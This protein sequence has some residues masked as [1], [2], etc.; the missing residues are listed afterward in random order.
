MVTLLF[1]EFFYNPMVRKQNVQALLARGNKTKHLTAGSTLWKGV[2]MGTPQRL[3]TTVSTQGNCDSPSSD[4]GVDAKC[5][6]GVK[7]I[8][9]QSQ[10][11]SILAGVNTT[12]AS[13]H[14]K[15]A[16]LT[17]DNRTSNK[18]GMPIKG[19]WDIVFIT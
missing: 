5:G 10:N 14:Q 13:G 7:K 2:N 18:V 8:A 15:V 3:V 9:Q 4:T 6:Q 12:I 1:P 19:G 11:N 16:P 17:R